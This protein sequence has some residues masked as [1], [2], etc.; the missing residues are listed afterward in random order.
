MGKAPEAKMGM[1]V[2]SF[3]MVQWFNGSMVQW[4]NGAMEQ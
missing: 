4:F 2:E 1:L 3:S